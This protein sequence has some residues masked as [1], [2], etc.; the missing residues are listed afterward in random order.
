MVWERGNPTEPSM[1]CSPALRVRKQPR[2]DTDPKHHSLTL[3]EPATWIAVPPP[4]PVANILGVLYRRT[5]PK[6]RFPQK[7]IMNAV[8]TEKLLHIQIPAVTLSDF[9]QGISKAFSSFLIVFRATEE[10]NFSKFTS[11]VSFPCWEG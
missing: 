6:F 5:L 1:I 7:A 11:R 4:K 8:I 10:D 2:G 9:Q 3:Y